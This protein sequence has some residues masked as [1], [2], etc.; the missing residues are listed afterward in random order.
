MYLTNNLYQECTENPYNSIL[1]IQFQ[2]KKYLSL[3]FK[4]RC[5]NQPISI[6]KDI[7][8]HQGTTT[9]NMVQV[10]TQYTG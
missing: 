4:N 1:R 2:E 6:C 9:K 10:H 3:W 7:L 5:T 8:Y